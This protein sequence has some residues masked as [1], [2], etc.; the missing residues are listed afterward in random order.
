[1]KN[2]KSQ[3]MKLALAA[4]VFCG[5]MVQAQVPGGS[6]PAPAV[7][8]PQVSPA[9]A[10][11][12]KLASSGVGDEVVMA[13]I[14]NSPAV[15]DLSADQL[16]YLKDVG[17]SSQVVT[18]ML[19][20]DNALK[21]QAQAAA[22]QQVE[23]PQPAPAPAPAQPQPQQQFAPSA[24]PGSAPQGA[25]PIAASGPG[26]VAAPAPTYVG[27]A[28]MEV[29]YFYNDLSPYGTWVD[30][31]GVGWCWQPSAVVVTPGWRPYC[32]GGRWVW[33]D[34]G[35]FWQSDYSW[36]WAPFHYGRWYMDNR[37]GWVW[38]PG[39]TWGPAWVTW[40]S[41][42]TTCGWAPLPPHAD[43]VAGGG[44]RYNGVTVGASFDFG[45]GV[46]AFAFVSF[47]NLC[48]PNVATYCLPRSQTTVIY[49]QTTVINNY[50]VN[51][52]TYVNRGIGYDRIAAASRTPIP[53]ASVQNAPGGKI[54]STGAG[55]GVVYREPLR[56]PAKPVN[57]LAQKVD[58]GR[59]IQH[60][61]INTLKYEPKNNVP[62]G[63]GGSTAGFQR[64]QN[65][66]QS[67][68]QNAGQTGKTPST[69][70]IGKQ[71]SGQQNV[72]T[73]KPQNGAVTHQWSP[74]NNTVPKT[75]S[76]PQ[77][78]TGGTGGQQYPTQPTPWGKQ[79][80]RNNTTTSGAAAG[81]TLPGQGATTKQDLSREQGGFNY[82]TANRTPTV[83][84][85]PQTF[86]NPGSQTGQQQP[87]THWYAPKSF[88]QAQE[89]R[90][91]P[92]TETPKQ[93]TPSPSSGSPSSYSSPSGQS[94]GS[95]GFNQN[96][97]QN[98]N[99]FRK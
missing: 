38:L 76:K 24:Q 90:S 81:S 93:V 10:E 82:N 14:R 13:Y 28:P 65:Q 96:F 54:P 35:W 22:P 39:T 36:G 55:N 16:L 78:T 51:N 12:V 44:W 58:T 59:T 64:N 18:A 68:N 5:G 99:Q 25:Q 88:Q 85:K 37:C 57:M 27:S 2:L 74:P 43:F 9:A 21:S 30:L 47:G 77:T 79:P 53:R 89:I 92:K 61:S 62:G 91:L 48:S 3:G 8:V 69:A 32:N 40:R 52:N 70:V 75:D 23:Q 33:T 49:K 29:S 56:S 63:N 87:N 86:A 41:V 97:N 45:L 26:P 6:A 31:A 80:Q 84:N 17:L 46:N 4:L 67:F 15:F 7:A 71:P 60:T 11:V 98:N 1:M 19:D 42:G 66:N 94:R 95:S 20:H 83:N 73:G 34:A 72:T 50:V